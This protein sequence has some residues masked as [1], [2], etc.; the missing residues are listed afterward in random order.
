MGLPHGE[1]ELPDAW[2]EKIAQ[3]NVILDEDLTFLPSV[4]TSAESPAFRSVV[5]NYQERRIYHAHEHI[6]RVI[7]PERIP[8][9][10]RVTPVLG[11]MI[12]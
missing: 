11:G 10:L 7:G 12:E 9:H 2:K 4:Q 8:E 1:A 6:D 3:F 5:V